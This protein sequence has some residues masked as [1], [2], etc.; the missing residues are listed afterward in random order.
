LIRSPSHFCVT[1]NN[2]GCSLAYLP[3]SCRDLSPKSSKPRAFS[4]HRRDFFFFFFFRLPPGFPAVRTVA[5]KGSG[6]CTSGTNSSHFSLKCCGNRC[7]FLQSAIYLFYP[8]VLRETSERLIPPLCSLPTSRYRLPLFFPLIHP[9]GQLLL[10]PP[11]LAPIPAV[12][13]LP[14][15]SHHR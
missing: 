8:C 2:S 1:L 10:S 5:Y 7:C 14:I 15:E 4:N 13:A 3:S 11:W 9:D 6:M 12:P